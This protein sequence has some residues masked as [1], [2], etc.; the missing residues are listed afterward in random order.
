MRRSDR[1]SAVKPVVVLRRAFCA[2]YQHFRDGRLPSDSQADV[3]LHEYGRPLLRQEPVG[4]D[5]QLTDDRC[6]VRFLLL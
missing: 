5:S 4:F 1:P 2:A 3:A 6:N